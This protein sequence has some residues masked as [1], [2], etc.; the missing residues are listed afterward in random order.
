MRGRV[1]T[2]MVPT[3]DPT[4]ADEQA[5]GFEPEPSTRLREMRD[6]LSAG[7]GVALGIAPHVLHH[8][9]SRDLVCPDGLG[10]LAAQLPQ[11]PSLTPRSRAT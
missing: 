9:P 11:V 2:D 4:A 3:T 6:S 10:V 7:V 1:S 8:R 5:D